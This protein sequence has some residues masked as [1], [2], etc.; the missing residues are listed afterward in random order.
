[1][2]KL[3][4][5]QSRRVL[6]YTYDI[7]ACVLAWCF[8]AVFCFNRIEL[9]AKFFEMGIGILAVIGIQSIVFYRVK[10][11]RALWRFTSIDDSYDLL[12][13][14]LLTLFI[15]QLIALSLGFF[16][17]WPI[18]M[19][20]L[21]GIFVMTGL[22][23]PRFLIRL[24]HHKKNQPSLEKNALIIGAGSAGEKLL[25]DLLHRKDHPYRVI[26]FLDDDPYK[27]GQ[28]VHNR[29]ILGSTQRIQKIVDSYQITKVFLAIPSANTQQMQTLM[30]HCDTAQVEVSTLP[31]LND[32]IDGRVTVDLLKGLS[33]EDLIG[34]SE[35]KLDLHSVAAHL[36]GKTV[37]VTGAGGSIGFELTRQILA[38]SPER[39]IVLDHSEFALYQLERTL[40]DDTVQSY[41]G[42]VC[43]TF[44]L[45]NI[46]NQHTIDFIFHAAA[47]KHVP[48]LERNVRVAITHNVFG[49]DCLA[50]FAV[51]YAVKK[52]ILISSDKA[53]TPVNVMGASKR[54][55]ELICQRY[56]QHAKTLFAIVR[57]GNV[58]DSQGSV[59]PLFKSQL[60]AGGPLTVTHPKITRYFMSI[61][62]AS[63]LILQAFSISQKG[64][65]YI[66]DM[67]EP[68]SIRYLAEQLIRLAGKIPYQ[69]IA[70][71]YTGL[72]PGEKMHEA[73]FYDNE[74][75]AETNYPK[76]FVRTSQ[77][78]V[79][80]QLSAQLTALKKACQNNDETSMKAYL[81]S[82]IRVQLHDR[83]HTPTCT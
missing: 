78:L 15:L 58:L 34:R 28:T 64:A 39:L 14:V 68:I 53:V 11:Y 30:N 74:S 47:Y 45:E 70:I 54:L 77:G 76:I 26:G 13:S 69:E 72:R 61:F 6:I 2:L 19:L 24:Y 32:I 73:L 57:F 79:S 33:I 4:N 56:N 41:L 43:D 51:K 29:P 48:L 62:E 21:Y 59:L 46:F 12:K 3:W 44:L 75:I 38:L 83:H 42:N 25:R 23:G 71:E 82:C 66:L 9:F 17:T 1:M 27:K 50:R 36:S 49:T 35:K 31:S 18:A 37:L 16:P 7:S 40:K 52:F 60:A 8:S 10:S 20:S 81:F 5:A 80:D 67:G 22:M 63:C 55:A 65:I